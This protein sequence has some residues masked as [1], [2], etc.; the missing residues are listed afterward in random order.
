MSNNF[1]LPFYQGL[2]SNTSEFGFGVHTS[3]YEYELFNIW[4]TM[5]LSAILARNELSKHSSISTSH[6][7]TA[8]IIEKPLPAPPHKAGLSRLG[9]APGLSEDEK[10]RLGR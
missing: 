6:P 4:V 1:K 2:L 7:Q 8:G 5:P 10:G 3:S 9:W